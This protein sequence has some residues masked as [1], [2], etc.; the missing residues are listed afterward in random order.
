V[1]ESLAI[2]SLRDEL[3][4]T[5]NVA[6]FQ[7][8]SYGPVPRSTQQLMAR[9]LATESV[10]VIASGSKGAGSAYEAIADRARSAFA[11]LLRVA[12]SSLAWS[13]NTTRAIRLA[14][15]SIVWRAGDQLALTDVEH[16]STTEFVRGLEERFGIGVTVIPTGPGS[17]YDPAAVI[18]E[19]ER[20]LTPHHRLLIMS[21]VANTD[22]RRLPV[23]EAAAIG[24]RLGV[25]VL[26]D[27][28]QAVG[29]FSV[30]V[31][32]MDPDFY[33]GSAHKWLMGPAGVGLLVVSPRRIDSYNPNALP[34]NAETPMAAGPR[35][36]LG[37]ANSVLRM[38]AAHSLAL[39]TGIG[40]DHIE[41]EMRG[42]TS[43]LRQGLA[44]MPGVANV[45]PDAWGQSSGI[46]T[47]AF[48]GHDEARCRAVVERLRDDH[49]IVTK[50][51]P[52]V[53]GVRVSVAAFN[54]AQEV[55][56]L[57]DVLERVIDQ[58]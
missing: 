45:G 43:R 16:K 33:A 52:E 36:E 51:R 22:G 2:P 29:T 18:R 56:C 12:P 54:T 41:A 46:T 30:D 6:Y 57:L 15:L 13:E 11:D 37:T 5:R 42:L 20:R 17:D 50:Y 4:I 32:A 47:F 53:C 34:I 14:V 21:H 19:L 3:P 58:T 25:P 55:D 8:G 40:I 24:R 31:G 9:M 10:D 44:A 1:I 39:L 38:G 27:G 48:T 49:R 26:I 7:T 23:D 35:S 28:A